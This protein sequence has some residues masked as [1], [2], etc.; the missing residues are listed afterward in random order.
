M[1]LVREKVLQKIDFFFSLLLRLS[2]GCAHES[3]R[4]IVCPE[5]VK[6]E[7]EKNHWRVLQY[8]CS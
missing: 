1:N 6:E 4:S 7:E 3:L 5:A 8:P 2:S